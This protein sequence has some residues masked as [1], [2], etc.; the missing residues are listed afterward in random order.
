MKK[1]LWILNKYIHGKHEQIY[2]PPFLQSCQNEMAERGFQLMFVFFSNRFKSPTTIANKFFYENEYKSMS[3]EYVRFEAKRIEQ[4]Y[5]FTF[6]QAYFADIIQVS[7]SQNSRKIRV[8]E[9]EFDKLTE[10]VCQFL[11]LERIITEQRID[12]CFC[13]QSPECQMEF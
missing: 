5:S 13:D 1:V 4:E 7:K 12:I 3:E 9:W 6:K 8:P 2:Y 10:L 11:Y